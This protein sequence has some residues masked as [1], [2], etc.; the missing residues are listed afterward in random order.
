MPFGS[1]SVKGKR[2]FHALLLVSCMILFVLVGGGCQKIG[3]AL[4]K[5]FYGISEGNST[6][7]S[8]LSGQTASRDLAWSYGGIRFACHIQVQQQL[9]DWDLKIYQLTAGFYG[10]KYSQTD[11]AFVP[12]ELR[13]LVLSDSLQAGGDLVPWVNDI[14]NSQLTGAIANQLASYARRNGFDGFHTAEFIQ[15]F[16]CGAI[17][18]NV[19]YAPELPAQTL[20][21]NGD[22]KDKSIL[23]AALLKSL[24]YKVV[25]LDFPPAPGKLQGTWRWALPLIRASCREGGN[26]PTIG[27]RG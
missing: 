9:L 12:V 20:M 23:L 7:I 19:T 5:M 6:V 26:C 16:V 3:Q 4:D 21:D 2:Y 8:S 13:R 11:L 15:S 14:H 22:C 18:Y 24:S 27:T 17:P 25:L 1:P 10:G